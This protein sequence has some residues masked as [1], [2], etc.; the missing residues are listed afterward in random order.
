[1]TQRY[2]ILHTGYKASSS[3]ID[4]G[5]STEKYLTPKEL[6][7][8]HYNV[9]GRTVSEPVT[10]VL[11]DAGGTVVVDS[12]DDIPVTI[13][14]DSEV[15]FPIWTRLT[16]AKLGLGNGV[17]VAGED[18]TMT[19]NPATSTGKW[20]T[21]MRVA[22][23]TW[24]ID[25]GEEY[26]LLWT[27]L[28]AGLK[29]N[30]NY[31]IL[32]ITRQTYDNGKIVVIVSDALQGGKQ[33]VLLSE[34][35]EASGT[36]ITPEFGESFEGALISGNNIVVIAIEESIVKIMASANLGTSW[37]DITPEFGESFGSVSILGNSIVVTAIEEVGEESIVKIMAS[38][39]LGT[40]WTDITPEG[41]NNG[42][43][44]VSGSNLILLY[45]TGE[46]VRTLYTSNNLGASWTDVNPVEIGEVEDFDVSGDNIVASVATIDE[47]E[48]SVKKIFSSQNLGATWID[49]TPGYGT[50]FDRVYILGTQLGVLANE[51]GVEKKYMLS[52][53]MGAAW[54][55]VDH[56]PAEDEIVKANLAGTLVFWNQ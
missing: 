34:D 13:P 30:G 47:E 10:L 39:N 51:G 21:A 48:N 23:N 37:T 33:I 14:P 5:T 49:V 15:N 43:A 6:T 18:V 46:Y 26:T 11:T 22:A 20:V 17:F 38:A 25:G 52:N 44:L 8:S 45:I 50:A 42:F 27:D 55:E 31:E 24:L 7:D 9:H 19:G 3:D 16:L 36:D 1:M 56:T 32:Y 12:L 4:V 53:N 2:K 40:S 35:N 41:M 28:L 29:A 54:S